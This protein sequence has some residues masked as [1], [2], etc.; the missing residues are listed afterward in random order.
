MTDGG[1]RVY[2]KVLDIYLEIASSN[3][4]D[5]ASKK[6]KLRLPIFPIEVVRSLLNDVT[7]HFKNEDTLL[8]LMSPI[9]VIGDIHGHILDLFR[10]FSIFEKPPAQSFL[11]LGDFVDRGEFSTEVI[12]FIYLL[13]VLFPK[14]IYL[15]RGNHEFRA[16][17]DKGPLSQELYALYNNQEPLELMIN[18][19]NWMP[20]GALIDNFMLCIHG[21]I[22]PSFCSI[23]QIEGLERPIESFENNGVV[24]DLLWGDPTNDCPEY[25]PSPRGEGYLYGAKVLQ[26]FIYS[27]RI[28]VIIRGHEAIEQGVLNHFN[29][30]IV[31]VFSASN[32]CGELGN[33][34]GVITVK[35]GLTYDKHIFPPLGYIKRMEAAHYVVPMNSLV[36]INTLPKK[37]ESNGNSVKT[38]EDRAMTT[39]VRSIPLS[40]RK[41]L[42]ASISSKSGNLQNV[43]TTNNP[44]SPRKSSRAEQRIAMSQL[45]LYDR[46]NFTGNRRQEVVSQRKS[47][48]KP[49]ASYLSDNSASR[50]SSTP[51]EK[52]HFPSDRI[53]APCISSRLFDPN[54]RPPHALRRDRS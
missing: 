44:S 19:F 23:S 27:N 3:L 33:K 9:I 30:K 16:M 36:S 52:S 6:K 1:K 18:S 11:F 10:I 31:T 42:P 32:Y 24:S 17:V 54:M 28:N 29:G 14:N 20:L 50:I 26:Q 13:K 47:I 51:K 45:S 8:K 34:A 39:N 4:D 46:L 49:I 40:Q 22:G 7:Y 5:Y 53:P 15:V 25:S 38:D 37:E 21:G 35:P 43:D 12:L 2:R 41:S 48:D